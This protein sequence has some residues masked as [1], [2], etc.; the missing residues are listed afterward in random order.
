MTI[1]TEEDYQRALEVKNEYERL[2]Q[3]LLALKRNAYFDALS[4]VVSAADYASAKSA[5]VAVRDTTEAESFFSVYLV[6]AVAA[7]SYLENAMD[8][9]TPYVP[10]PTAPESDSA[11]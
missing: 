4:S 10:T 6:N 11:A 8:H 2:Q 7:L 9:Y 5:L 1:P 3:E